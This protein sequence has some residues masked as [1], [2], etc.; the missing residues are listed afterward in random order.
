MRLYNERLV[1]SLIRRYGSLP[2]AEIARVTGLSAQT[3]SVI[4]K[5]LEADGLLLR[6]RPQRGRI[7]RERQ[8]GCSDRLPRAG[9][10]NCCP[11]SKKLLIVGQAKGS[12]VV[13]VQRIERCPGRYEIFNYIARPRRSG[14]VQDG[15]IPPRLRSSPVPRR[16]AT[17]SGT[18]RRDTRRGPASGSKG[19]RGRGKTSFTSK[20]MAESSAT[21]PGN[22]KISPA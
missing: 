19:S 8:N 7:G 12:F 6:Q 10:F 9:A 16:I 13:V 3:A 20:S 4:V 22:S 5:Q 17:N 1:L 2:K 14:D 11:P 15:L 18:P 21:S